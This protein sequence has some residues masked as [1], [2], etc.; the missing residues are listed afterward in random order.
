MFTV[1]VGFAGSFDVIVTEALNVP[2][3]VGAKVTVN[4]RAGEPGA[5]AA[6]SVKLA[7]AVS[8]YGAPS[9]ETAVTVTGRSPVLVRANVRVAV[10]PGTTQPKF[11]LS[12]ATVS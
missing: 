12:G 11:R 8:E 1:R 4:V 5:M 9:A 6:P 2:T 3:A 10:V 7:G